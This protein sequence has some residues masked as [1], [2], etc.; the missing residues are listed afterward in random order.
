MPGIFDWRS[1]FVHPRGWMGA[2]TGLLLSFKNRERSL[3]V[4]PLLGLRAT[5]RVLEI[6]YGPGM[7]IRRVAVL[8]RDG[9]VA[10]IDQSDVMLR[11][12]SRRNAAAIRKGRVD[13]RVGHASALPYPDGSFDVVFAINV[14]QF[15]KDPAHT[16]AGIHRVLKPGGRIGLAVQPRNKDATEQTATETGIKLQAALRQAGFQQIRV[17]RKLIKPVSTVCVLGVK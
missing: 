3:W 8:A 2:V 5:D 10:G 7:D 14:A 6:G 9:F 12:A 11:Q 4:I 13:L 1:Q 17:E 15:W 16:A